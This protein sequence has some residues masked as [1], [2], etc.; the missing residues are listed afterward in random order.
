MAKFLLT[1]LFLIG[2]FFGRMKSKMSY[3]ETKKVLD[4]LLNSPS[5]QARDVVF[6]SLTAL[7]FTEAQF[8][9]SMEEHVK[10]LDLSSNQWLRLFQVYTGTVFRKRFEPSKLLSENHLR[11]LLEQS[12]L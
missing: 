1:I 7:G 5:E 2:K 6:Q 8:H 4:D 12:K 11:Q 3:T 9:D 10:P